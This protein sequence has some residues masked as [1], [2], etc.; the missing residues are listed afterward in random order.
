MPTEFDHY[1]VDG[2]AIQDASVGII[3]GMNAGYRSIK[4]VGDCNYRQQVRLKPKV[5]LQR[6]G[7]GYDVK[8]FN[9]DWFVVDSA[10]RVEGLQVEGQGYSGSCLWFPENTSMQEVYNCDLYRTNGPLIDMARPAAGAYSTIEVINAQQYDKTQP[11][12]VLP[13]DELETTGNRKF[14]ACN[15]GG[16]RLFHLGGAN[17]THITDCDTYGIWM[18]MQCRNTIFVATRLADLNGIAIYGYNHRF[19]GCKIFTFVAFYTHGVVYGHDNY[20]D[21]RYLQLGATNNIIADVNNKPTWNYSGNQTNRR[22]VLEL[23]P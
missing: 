11:A 1:V 15:G 9:G 12:I 8:H 16:G 13:P 7:Y 20:D 22:P 21:G 6:E 14:R 5:R 23:I 19:V 17:F 10:C 4:L 2:A 3:N 18:T